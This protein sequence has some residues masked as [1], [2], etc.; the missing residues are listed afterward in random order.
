MVCVEID[1]KNFIIT[2]DQYSQR[3]GW[4]LAGTTQFTCS[5]CQT[6]VVLFP[7]SRNGDKRKCHV[8]KY[9][10]ANHEE[11][12]RSIYSQPERSSSC[13]TSMKYDIEIS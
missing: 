3:K 5:V 7:N 12:K 1:S 10:K 8:Q 6:R 9:L 2:F 11:G 13:Y 4:F